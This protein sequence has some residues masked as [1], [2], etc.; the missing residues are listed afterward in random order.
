[1]DMELVCGHG[2]RQVETLQLLIPPG[3]TVLQALEEALQKGWRLSLDEHEDQDEGGNHAQ[4]PFTLEHP[5]S[6]LQDKLE[7]GKLFLSIWGEPC[8]LDSVLEPQDRLE[9]TK[10]IRVDPKVA[11][12][13][14]FKLQGSKA[15]G[16]FAKKR[17]G[18]KAGY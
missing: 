18:A 13:E 5:R 9:V 1:M 3:S 10:P 17:A 7:N 14:R 12:R 4:S 6:Y 8:T 15:A 2:F 16:L 11:R